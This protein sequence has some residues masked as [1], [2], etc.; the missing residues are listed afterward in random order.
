[1][2]ITAFPSNTMLEILSEYHTETQETASPGLFKSKQRLR[3][4]SWSTE[5]ME[6][7]SVGSEYDKFHTPKNLRGELRHSTYRSIKG[8]Y[9]TFSERRL[10]RERISEEQG[11][12]ESTAGALTVH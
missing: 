4:P 7:H 3:R 9:R 2:I 12:A 11:P 5:H 6:K 1:M 8:Q 10:P